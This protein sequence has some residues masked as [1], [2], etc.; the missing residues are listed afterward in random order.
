MKYTINIGDSQQTVEIRR[1]ATGSY[2]CALDGQPIEADIVAVAP[3]VY[4]V[5]WQ[6][7]SFEVRVER[8]PGGYRVNARGQEFQVSVHDPR[9]LARHGGLA[10]RSGAAPDAEGR[11]NVTAPMPGKVVKVLVREKVEVEA[12][13]GLVVVEA[14]KMQNEIRS[15]KKGLVERIYVSEG[16]SVGAG[17]TLLVVS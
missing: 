10:R 14:M 15:P 11:Q 3:G 2:V 4:S 7:E 9:R 6:G 17:E 1:A 16:A 13:Q 8:A 5:L 12:G